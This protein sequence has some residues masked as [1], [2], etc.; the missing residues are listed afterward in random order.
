MSDRI[1]RPLTPTELAVLQAMAEG[2]TAEETASRRSISWKT[3][4]SHRAHVFVKLGAR[5]APHAV[6]LGYRLG[7]LG[8]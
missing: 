3:V 8:T 7:L 6:A 4:K 5:N 2:L 1:V